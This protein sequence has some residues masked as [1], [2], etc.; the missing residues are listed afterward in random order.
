[1]TRRFALLLSRVATS[2]FAKVNL[3]SPFFAI[4]WRRRVYPTLPERLKAG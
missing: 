4:A 3:G 1:M 2:R